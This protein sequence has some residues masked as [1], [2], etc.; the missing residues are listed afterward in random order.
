MRTLHPGASCVRPF[1]RSTSR[2]DARPSTAYPRPTPS[3]AANRTDCR[4]LHCRAGRRSASKHP[5]QL[6]RNATNRP[7]AR[8]PRSAP[9]EVAPAIPRTECPR[10]SAWHREDHPRND[11]R[12]S[13]PRSEWR[14]GTLDSRVTAEGGSRCGLPL[15]HQP[16][17]KLA[18]LARSSL[19]HGEK[20]M[21]SCDCQMAFP[22]EVTSGNTRASF[23]RQVH[24]RVRYPPSSQRLSPLARSHQ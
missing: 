16:I 23:D 4:D 7:R 18:E 12:P 20:K 3:H 24:C 10:P 5:S 15:P 14:K 8:P 17:G 9:C 13:M 19:M 6:S 2:Q 11:P 1:T 21:V 22:V